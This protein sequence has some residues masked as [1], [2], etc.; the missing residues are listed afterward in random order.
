MTVNIK[1]EK[2]YGLIGSILVIVGRFLGITPY[3]R[4]IMSTVSLVGQ[5][6]ILLSLK[7]IGDKLGDDRPFKYY[8]YSVVSGIVGAI[9]A[10]IFVAIG[11]LSIPAFVDE[12]DSISTVG[13]SFLGLGVLVLL[14][15]AII[16]IYYAI[17]TWRTMYRL[18]GVEEFDKT[19]T[20]LKWGAI[21][22]IILVGII[23][24][25]IA[26]VFQ[27]IAFSKLPDELEPKGQ[28]PEYDT[29]V[30]VY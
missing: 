15:A 18:T 20:F 23:L 7:G 22:L 3:I 24:L 19:A 14:A 2:N 25:L 26:E 9:V 12:A 1:S 6:L 10:L 16:G 13:I 17:K 29:G 27:I 21:T 4:I 8:L 5:V 11:I 28:K 30:V